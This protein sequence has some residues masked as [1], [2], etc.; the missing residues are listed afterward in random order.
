MVRN[1]SGTVQKF[2][3]HKNDIIRLETNGCFM[4]FESRIITVIVWQ[5]FNGLFDFFLFLKENKVDAPTAMKHIL[6]IG[7]I[8]VAIK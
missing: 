1:L 5:K 3:N 4:R 7:Q 6:C 2:C 8:S